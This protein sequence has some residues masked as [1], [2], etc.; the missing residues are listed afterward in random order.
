[1]FKK[2]F[3]AALAITG[4]LISHAQ[5]D[6]AS[7]QP[8]LSVT[9]SADLYYRYDFS[10]T[11]TNNL[12]SFTNS[13]NRFELGMASIKLEH[14]TEKLDMVADLGFGKRAQEFSYTDGNGVLSAIK[15]LYISYSPATWVK[16]TAGTMATH[17]GYELVDAYLNRNYSMS[18]M[19]TNGPFAH[20]GLKMDLTKGKSGFMLGIANPTDYKYVPDDVM[21]KKF[22]LA[23]YSLA[24][25]D[26]FKIY[27]NYVGGQGI[28]TSKSNQFDAVITAKISDKFSIA[29]N[30]TVNNTKLHG[31]NGKLNNKKNWWG[32][33]LYFNLDPTP[34]FGLTLRTEYFSDK[35]QLKV[36]SANPEGGTVFATT[37]SA[38]IRVSSFILVPELRVDNSSKELFI[39]NNQRSGSTAGSFLVAAIYVF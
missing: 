22:L 11:R 3:S 4:A 23:Q 6:S 38:N 36:Y 19:F 15:Q 27:L 30:G 13:H 8:A 17:V 39:K 26:N 5:T 31:G 2:I 25:S 33:A 34:A 7:V 20:T 21:N 12:T 10:K 28:D 18:Y 9:G 14:K 32:S 29:Y 1:M 35:N 16:F 24:V 37:L